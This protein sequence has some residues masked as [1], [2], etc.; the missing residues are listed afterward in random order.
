MIFGEPIIHSANNS[1]FSRNSP[2]SKSRIDFFLCSKAFIQSKNSAQSEI[3]DGYLTDHNLV[4]LTIEINGCERGRS[5]WKFNNSLLK[6]DAF[7]ELMKMRIPQILAENEHP[8]TSPGLILDTL[9]AVLRGDIISYATRR[10]KELVG[11]FEV[12]QSEIDTISQL[13]SPTAAQNG[14]LQAAKDEREELIS[15][16]PTIICLKRK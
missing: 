14:R 6:E 7:V 10:K 15:K 16:C 12:I 4:S 13:T 11:K 5:Y 3:V 9:L 2:P 1:L 8:E